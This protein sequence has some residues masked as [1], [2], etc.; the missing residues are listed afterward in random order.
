MKVIQEVAEIAQD[1]GFA[2]ASALALVGLF[3]LIVG[4]FCAAFAALVVAGM[5]AGRNP[6]PWI[7]E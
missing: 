4:M 1:I 3:V 7:G 2:F 5:L 6:E